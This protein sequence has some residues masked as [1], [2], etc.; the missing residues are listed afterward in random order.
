LKKGKH[1]RPLIITDGIFALTGEIAP[2]DQYYAL[3]DKFNAILVVDDAHSTGVLGENGRGTAEH[4]N[5][6]GARNIFQSGT[7]S[8]ALGSYGGFVTG[9]KDL[10]D[11]IRSKSAFYGASTALPP[12]VVAAG[13]SSIRYIKTHPELRLK[14]KEN[15]VLVRSGI[16]EMEFSTTT[17]I[18]P[19]I[20]V[21][22]NNRKEADNLSKYLEKN[23]IIAS[24]MNYPVEMDKFILRITV[25]VNHTKDQIGELLHLLKKWR[26]KQYANAIFI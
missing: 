20:P 3:A 5:L 19:I 12:P 6:D 14:L 24:L 1:H 22:F 23:N 25:S 8:K 26:D 7:M 11:K 9:G 10:I 16:R 13:C 15:A 21:I 2:L 4:F 17:G 18:T